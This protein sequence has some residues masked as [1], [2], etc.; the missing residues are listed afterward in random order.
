[1]A[2]RTCR[3]HASVFVRESSTLSGVRERSA[4]DDA[5][6]CSAAAPVRMRSAIKSAGSMPAP[7]THGFIGALGLDGLKKAGRLSVTTPAGVGGAYLVPG[8]EV[9]EIPLLERSD[10]KQVGMICRVEVSTSMVGRV[11]ARKGTSCARLRR[12]GWIDRGAGRVPPIHIPGEC[13]GNRVRARR[14]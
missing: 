12:G 13:P 14:K 7:V 5:S 1:M 3:Y 10:G 6:G 8:S 11:Q 4:L 9:R 2:T